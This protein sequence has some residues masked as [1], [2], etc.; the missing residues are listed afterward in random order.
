MVVDRK[1]SSGINLAGAALSVT[2]AAALVQTQRVR[3]DKALQLGV[4]PLAGS[5]VLQWVV[6]TFTPAVLDSERFASLSGPLGL[7]LPTPH[8]DVDFAFVLTR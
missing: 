5:G 3:F 1:P 7:I 4:W 2:Q 8:L 6:P